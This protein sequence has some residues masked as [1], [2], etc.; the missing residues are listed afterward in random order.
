MFDWADLVLA[1]V[2][3]SVVAVWIMTIFVR[4]WVDRLRSLLEE[5][6]AEELNKSSATKME[7]NDNIVPLT[8]EVENNLYYCYNSNTNQFVCQGAN[9]KELTD[10]FQQRFP[11]LNAFFNSG[12]E[13]AL[14]TL[15]QQL[16]EN[17]ENSSS[18]G[19]AS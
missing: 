1:F 10:Q 6:L 5:A 3:G 9:V 8:V 17:C 11:G 12:D 18:I 4:R 13:A 19:S 16:K 14:T 7:P 15:R 2:A